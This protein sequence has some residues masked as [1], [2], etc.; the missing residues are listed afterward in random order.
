MSELRGTPIDDPADRRFPAPIVVPLLGFEIHNPLLNGQSLILTNRLSKSPGDEPSMKMR[1]K[2]FITIVALTITIFVALY[3][4]ASFVLLRSFT[5][6]EEQETRKSVMQTTNSLMNELSD[7]DSKVTDWAFWDDTYRFVQDLNED[8]VTVNLADETFVNLRLNVILIVNP[9][10]QIVLSRAFDLLNQSETPVPLSL[11]EHVTS[12]S[13]LWNY[14][15]ESSQTIGFISIPDAS[16]MI[17]SKPILTSQ[18]EGPIEGALIFGRYLDSREIE[19]LAQIDGLSLSLGIVGSTNLPSDF[20]VAYS[21]MSG[22]SMVNVETL[23]SDVIAGYALTK[24]VY[25]DPT[26]ML[27]IDAPRDI[28][29]QGLLTINYFLYSSVAICIIFGGAMLIALERGVVY[30]ISRVTTAIKEMGRSF[31]E[32]HSEPRLGTDEIS[33][34]TQAIKTA[35]SQRLAAIEELAGMIG[36]D[37]RN[38]LTGIA[39]AAYY[40]KTKCATAMDP[41]GAEMLRIIEDDVVYSNKII[42]DLLD[43][44]RKIHLEFKKTNP[45]VLMEKS[46]SLVTVPENVQLINE[47]EDLPVL[48]VDE[49]KLKRVFSNIIKNAFDAMPDGGVLRIKSRRSMENMEFVFADNGIGMSKE[50]LEKIWTPLFTTKAKGMGF[51]LPIT[52]RLVEAH[53]GSISVAS[54]PAEGTTFTVTVPV[55]TR[56]NDV[57]KE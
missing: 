6:L 57:V 34:L 32:I 22:N 47:T 41:R 51:G 17:A 53:G 55:T 40:L 13:L 20:R 24:D 4:L 39:T 38:P 36:H 21:K 5:A 18:D 33:L 37:L 1:L 3:A 11:I 10:G 28:Y 14:S 23:N 45:R 8:Y 35:M 15:L 48:T 52:K 19:Y 50:T 7:L 49:E 25:G 9:S 46:L 43:Y 16:I 56:T 42:N 26:F 2:A 27:R 30:P 44:S 12:H 29:Q 31:S 54:T